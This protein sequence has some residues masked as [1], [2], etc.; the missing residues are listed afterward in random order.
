[1]NPAALRELRALV[2]PEKAGDLERW[3]MRWIDGASVTAHV[4]ALEELLEPQDKELCAS[5]F[6]RRA[7]FQVRALV[8]SLVKRVGVLAW[9]QSHLDDGGTEV[10]LGLCVVRAEPK[11]GA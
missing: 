3:C 7:E 10:R 1:M 9:A 8:Q 5:L 4:S 11:E 6:A 2:G